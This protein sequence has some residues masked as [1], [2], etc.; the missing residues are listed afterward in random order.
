[1]AAATMAISSP[2]FAGNAVQITSTT[3]EIIGNGSVSMRKSARKVVLSGNP[4]YGPDTV[5]YLGLFSNEAPS[6]LTETFAKNRELEVIHS[7][8]AM[9]GA[10]ECVFPKLLARNGVKFGEA[11]WFKAGA[12]IFSEGGLDYLGNHLARWLSQFTQVEDDMC[13]FPTWSTTI[14]PLG[15][16][17][18]TLVVVLV[19]SSTQTS[20]WRH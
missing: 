19:V 5:K 12:Q 20:E 18:P 4:W 16:E 8:W 6:Y 17:F 7:R 11:V 9:L 13:C 1:M 15:L 10:L 3:S 14:P 2:S